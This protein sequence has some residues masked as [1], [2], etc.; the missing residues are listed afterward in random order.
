[1]KREDIAALLNEKIPS[2]NGA[3]DDRVGYTPLSNIAVERA[4]LSLSE[5]GANAVDATY[6]R[7]FVASITGSDCP[8]GF[9]LSAE[10]RAIVRPRVSKYAR[11]L[12]KVVE[13]QS[14]S[15]FILA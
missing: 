1:M 15:K 6:F 10:Q 2:F 7:P 8:K 3:V 13:A 9:R 5:K 4:V 11:Q 14:I 12:L